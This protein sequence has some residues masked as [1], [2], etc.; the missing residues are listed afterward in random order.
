MESLSPVTPCNP[1]APY[2]GGKRL[3]ADQV[4]K[5]ISA[6][7]HTTYAEAFVGMGGVFFRRTMRPDAEV[8]ND[9]SR[10]VANLFRILQRHYPQFLDTLKWQLSG[11]AEFER[12]MKVDPATLTDLERAGRFLYLQRLCY[13][14]KVASRVFGV[15]PDRPG[16]FD[17]TKLVP[18]LEDVHDRLAGVII[19]CLDYA[20]FLERYD[21]AGTLFYMDPPYYGCEGDYGAG[22]FSRAEFPKMAAQLAGLKAKFIVSLN[23]TPEVREIF[24]VFTIR[25]VQTTYTIGTDEGKKVNEVLISNYAGVQLHEQASML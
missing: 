9:Y 4:A 24:A 2:I 15:A 6:T 23:D 13:G 22:M 5:I 20:A 16:R 1:V 18:M 10:D 14:G 8:V 11:R 25:Q 12:L 7:P 17:L 19:E 3:L 21:A